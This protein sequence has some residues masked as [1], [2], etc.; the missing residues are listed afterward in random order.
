MNDVLYLIDNNVLGRLTPAQRKSSFLRLECVI[1]SDV[2]Y[3]A[4]GFSDE[5]TGIP[6]KEVTTSVVGHLRDV[7]AQVAPGDNSLV[8]L[9]ANKG[10]AD[11]VLVATALDMMDEEQQTLFPREIV[12]VT[13]DKAVVSSAQSMGIKTLSGEQFSPLVCTDA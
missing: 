4:R 2:L 11:P 10:A 9:Y 7:M 13:G 8:D 3:E 6:V 12:L 1:T 5:L